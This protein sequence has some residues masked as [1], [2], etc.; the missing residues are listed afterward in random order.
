LKIGSE[1]WD[2]GNTSD[3]DGWNITC[4]IEDNWTC[5]GSLGG[6]SVWTENSPQLEMTSEATTAQTV[7]TAGA[8]A[9]VVSGLTSLSNPTG[10]WQM[11]NTM[12]LFMLIL[13]L[14][15]YLPI[16]ILNVYNASSGFN[17]SFDVSFIT[18]IPY[19]GEVYE[20][21]D[22]FSPR[23]NYSMLGIG[24]GSTLINILSFILLLIVLAIIHIWLT[25]WR[26]VWGSEDSSEED[27]CFRNI[28]YKLWKFMSFNAYLR[29]MLQGYQHMFIASVLGIYFGD[30]GNAQ[31]LVSSIASIITLLICIIFPLV[32]LIA[33]CKDWKEG[34]NELS[35]GL[36]SN[37]YAKV[38][39]IVLILRKV[40]LISWM[41][42]F[43]FIP[44]T[45]YLIFPSIYQFFHIF[46]VFIYRPFT[47]V[48]DNIIEIYNEITF[49]LMLSGLIYLK[50]KSKWNGEFIDTY[51][52][53][54]MM[55]GIFMM[56]I[57]LSKFMPYT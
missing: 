20:Y 8:A 30:F 36:K 54:M 51:A 31:Q 33:L 35:V 2:D 16:R 55:P 1:D 24:S 42:W 4:Q 45:P 13:L 41:I 10:L 49:T 27:G 39:Q 9:S 7:A 21:L 37:S 3:G 15:V 46:Y 57:T 34:I 23:E 48:K 29:L 47:I 14:D 38:Y 19:V 56:L 43:K 52:Y 44:Q 53:L 25:P 50:S 32:S 22:F 18:K 5:V 26:I 12:Q 17:L 28:Y 40:V 6:I 11:I